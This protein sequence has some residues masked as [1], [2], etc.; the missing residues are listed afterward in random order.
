M[1]FRSIPYDR[2]LSTKFG[3]YAIQ[4]AIK[5]KFDRMAS[6]KGTEITSVP[7]I[8]SIDKQKLVTANIQDVAAASAVG[9]SFG[10]QDL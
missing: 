5:K 4:L 9:V 10:T 8:K 2:I 3:T 7:I 6:L 1:L